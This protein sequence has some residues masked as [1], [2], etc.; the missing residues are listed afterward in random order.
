MP[1][2]IIGSDRQFQVWKYTVGHSQLLLRSVKSSDH[3]TRIDV[4][5]K[6][7]S[8]FHLPTVLN[9]LVI[10]E[11][12][13]SDISELFTLRESEARKKELKLFPVRGVDFVGYVSALV[14]FTHEDEG[15]YYD[16]S[17][18]PSLKGL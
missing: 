5:F 18:F 3:P 14:V 10:A 12:A 13:E 8:Q 15:E 9:G 6:G 4:L 7:V 17:F 1:N 11:G 2:L 16:P